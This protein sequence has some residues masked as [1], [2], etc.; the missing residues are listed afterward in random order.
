MTIKTSTKFLTVLALAGTVLGTGLVVSANA[1]DDRGPGARERDHGSMGF[2]AGERFARADTNGDRMISLE[3]F[4]TRTAERF[5][6]LD[7]DG[8]GV[9]TPAE[10]VAERQQRAEERAAERMANA[11]TDGDGALSLEEMT[12]AGEERFA[13]ME[14]DEDGNLEPREIRR[15]FRDFR[16]DRD[17]RDGR[18]SREHERGDIQPQNGEIVEQS[19]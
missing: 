19:L 17:G 12:A 3:E 16:G 14:R 1:D 15:S 6:E 13:R 18:G 4:Q 11:D 2:R 5:V 8:D 10:M 9:V 7:A